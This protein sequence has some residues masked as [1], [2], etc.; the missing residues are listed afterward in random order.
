MLDDIIMNIFSETVEQDMNSVIYKYFAKM[1]DDGIYLCQGSIQNYTRQ[2]IITDT[3]KT[4]LSHNF[5]KK[6]C[7]Y[8]GGLLSIM[9]DEADL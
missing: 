6:L 5:M 7:K 1:N 2:K 8:L 3:N 4:L 9:I